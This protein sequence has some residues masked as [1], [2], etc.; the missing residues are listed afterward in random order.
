MVVE[1]G[2]GSQ[3]LFIPIVNSSGEPAERL[4]S[5][6]DVHLFWIEEPTELSYEEFK[7]IRLRLRGETLHEGYRQIIISY[8]HSIRTLYDSHLSNVLLFT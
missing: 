7:M 4:K 2:Q 8:M 5:L 3:I 6:S 1:L